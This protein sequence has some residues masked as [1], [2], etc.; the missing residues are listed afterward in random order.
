MNKL[1]Y[2][3]YYDLKFISFESFYYSVYIYFKFAD[4]CH[5]VL[6][7]ESQII[8]ACVYLLWCYEGWNLESYLIC[9]KNPLFI[10]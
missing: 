4:L 5:L 6:S 8:H 3:S 2:I 7:L 1:P 9:F 10:S